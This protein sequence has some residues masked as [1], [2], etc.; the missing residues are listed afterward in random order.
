MSIHEICSVCEH[1]NIH[2]FNELIDEDFRF[3]NEVN[4]E[5]QSLMH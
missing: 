2:R 1:G 3:I 4:S 5:N